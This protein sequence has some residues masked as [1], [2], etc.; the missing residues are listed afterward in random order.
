MISLTVGLLIS[1]LQTLW[2]YNNVYTVNEEQLNIILNASY[3]D[4]YY[5][6]WFQSCLLEGW[7]GSEIFSPFNNLFYLLFPLLAALPFGL[8]LY[9]EWNGGY[10]YQ[11]VSRCPRKTYFMAKAKAVFIS[12]GAVVTIPLILNLLMAACYLPAVGSD[13]LAN[14]AVVSNKEMWALLYYEKPVMYALAYIGVDFIFGGL[15]GLV[16]LVV[17]HLFERRFTVLMFPLLLHCCLYFGLDN[18]I[19]SAAKYNMADIINPAQLS[20]VNQEQALFVSVIGVS[21]ISVVIYILTNL[22][23]DILKGQ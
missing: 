15:Y 10:I 4:S 11:V 17:T 13:V 8:S 20:G 22:K 12:G 5:A 18:L 6:S 2:Y 23:K 3:T 19:T 14:Q 16:A 9:N 21:C 1:L 7:I